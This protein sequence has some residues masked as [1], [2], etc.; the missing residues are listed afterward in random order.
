MAHLGFRER[1]VGLVAVVAATLLTV[2]LAGP[3]P[4]AYPRGR[5]C[6]PLGIAH[7][8]KAGGAA[9]ENT[10]R[11]YSNALRT[12]VRTLETD[13]RFTADEV[14]VLMHDRTVDRT[15][16]G[17]GAVASLTWEDVHELDAGDG[18]HVPRLLGLTKLARRRGAD[19]VVELKPVS[20]S[21][22][23]MHRFLRVIRGSSLTGST[24]VQSYHP[25][26]LRLVHELAPK[27]ATGL[28]TRR[29]VSTA[30]ATRFGSVVLPTMQVVTRSRVRRWH[31]A[32]LV[33]YTWTA[34]RPRQWR[35]LADAKVDAIITD[36]PVGYRAWAAH[37]C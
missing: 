14:P 6:A 18:T 7:R 3:V 30:R 2:L 33:V 22:E 36:R 29:P 24:T 9:P 25:G 16:D 8:G 17:T 34:N 1:P 31:R 27:L 4:A 19:L 32:G 5:S 26:N 37:R 28:V 35:V 23:Q 10:L 12:G 13:V 20:V 21:R 15:T 11:A